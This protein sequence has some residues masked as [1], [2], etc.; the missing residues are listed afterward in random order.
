MKKLLTLLTLSLC[1]FWAY[2]EQ[3]LGQAANDPTASVVAFQIEDWYGLQYHNGDYSDNSVVFRPVIP[4][5]LW[6]INNIARM[7]VPIITDHP[8]A[9]TGLGDITVFNLMVANQSWGRWGV[10]AVGLLPTGGDSRGAS[11]WAAGPAVG[12]T[13]QT[14]HFIWGAFN[15]N[16][17]TLAG[18]EDRPEVNISYLQP[19]FSYGLK[20]G[21][22]LGLSEMQFA[23][24]WEKSSWTSLPLGA[25]LSKIVHVY[26]TPAQLS[27]QY[28]HNFADDYVIPS[29]TLRFGIKFMLP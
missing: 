23:Y 3:S 7:T 9:E 10:G 26:D 24:D 25:K 28:E 14:P 18:D 11:Q 15:Q 16:L 5:Q 20:D 2:S 22:S 19:L 1:S 21:W 4:F 27:F 29:D 17:F 8:F 6:G 13:A 12:F